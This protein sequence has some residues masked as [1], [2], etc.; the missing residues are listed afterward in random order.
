MTCRIG[1]TFLTIAQQSGV[2]A[3][4]WIIVSDPQ[5]NPHAVVLVNFTTWT[6]GKDQSCVLIPGDYPFINRPTAVN[7]REAKKTSDAKLHQLIEAGLLKPL[8]R[9]NQSVL[10]KILRGAEA[11]VHTPMWMLDILQ[12]QGLID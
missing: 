7:Y 8:E 12:Q 3:H 5:Q 4:L 11:S 6:H 2:T 9:I 1:D 10:D